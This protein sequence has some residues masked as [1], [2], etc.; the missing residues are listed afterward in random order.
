MDRI[1]IGVSIT[2]M[3]T[4]LHRSA[5]AILSCST[6]LFAEPQEKRT[7]N[8]AI[9]FLVAGQSNAGGCGMGPPIHAETQGYMFSLERAEDDVVLN[10]NK[11]TL[12]VNI[13][14]PGGIGKGRLYRAAGAVTWPQQI[15][16]LIRLDDGKPLGDLEGFSLEGARLRFTLDNVDNLG[17]RVEKTDAAM[18][19]VI[20]GK[21]LHGESELKIQWID[22]YRR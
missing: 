3:T 6:V 4:A 18:K 8:P 12:E 1:W 20:P 11:L 13:K 5:L 22:F 10:V 19:I 17:I 2:T 7:H 15:V 9:V 21:I 14:C 16:L